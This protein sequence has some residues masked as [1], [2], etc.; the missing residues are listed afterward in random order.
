MKSNSIKELTEKELKE[1]YGGN[2]PKYIW[3]FIEGAFR[4]IQTN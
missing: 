4:K 2:A 1:I 3:V